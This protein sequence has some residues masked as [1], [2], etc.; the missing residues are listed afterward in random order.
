MNDVH[1]DPLARLE[2]VLLD[3]DYAFHESRQRVASR[4]LK[5]RSRLQIAWTDAEDAKAALN[6]AAVAATASPLSLDAPQAPPETLVT[7][8]HVKRLELSLE[9]SYARVQDL[10]RDR[11]ELLLQLDE[12]RKAN[13]ELIAGRRALEHDLAATRA[14]LDAALAESDALRQAAPAAAPAE[15]PDSQQLQVRL[16]DIQ[17]ESDRS[18]AR[19]ARLLAA[20]QRERD[21][22]HHQVIALRAEAESLR[23]RVL[24]SEPFHSP[25]AGLQ[26]LDF[27]ESDMKRLRLGQILETRGIVTRAQLDQALE[28]KRKAPQKPLGAILVELGATD[29]VTIGKILASQLNLPYVELDRRAIDPAAATLIPAKLAR[30]HLCIPIAVERGQLVV[31]MSNPMDLIALEDLELATHRRVDPVIA[32]PSAI[33][34][35]IAQHYTSI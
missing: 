24:A 7:P 20:A 11:I 22:T 34:S 10:E 1:E 19:L 21:E 3:W 31:A 32:T 2:A 5:A 16:R 15:S 27:N 28:I 8:D 18:N 25:G 29:E 12:H 17:E 23:A 4:L 9:R 26:T 6:A 13:A 30:H 35:A 33:E 14:Q